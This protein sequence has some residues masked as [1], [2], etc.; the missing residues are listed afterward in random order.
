MRYLIVGNTAI[1]STRT[2]EEIG[3]DI[4]LET[5]G[6]PLSSL[7]VTVSIMKDGYPTKNYILKEGKTNI[8]VDELYG[9]GNYAIAF[10]WEEEDPE[11]HKIT[12]HEAYGNSFQV[13]KI[14]ELNCILPSYTHTTTDIDQMWNGIVQLLEE[15]IPFIEQYRY[16]NDAV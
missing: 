6:I 11:S 5:V 14:G 15:L 3:I 10:I 7:N 16:G 12:K 13:I 2:A 1:L 4:S 9:E 8:S